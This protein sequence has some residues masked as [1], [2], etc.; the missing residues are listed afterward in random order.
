[1]A[2]N[3]ALVRYANPISDSS[4]WD[5]FRFRADDIVI[6]TPP[7]CGTTW[8]QMMCALLIFQ[9]PTFDRGLDRISPWLD[10]LTR[11]L[12]E[13]TADLDAQTHRRFVKTHTP[14]DGLPFDQRVTY[15]AVGR[16]PR[17]V[18][19]SWDHHVANSDID[20]FVA[21]RERATGTAGRAELAARFAPASDDVRDRFWD[22]IEK[23]DAPSLASTLHHV[24][25]FWPLRN[26]PNVVLMHYAELQ[27]DLEG[28]MRILAARLGIDV[29]EDLWPTVVQAA[30]FDAMRARAD[31]LAPDTTNRIW[32]DNHAFFHRGTSGQWHDFITDDRDRERYAR[33]VAELIPPDTSLWLHRGSIT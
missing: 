10:M 14:F 19:L 7:K 24:S 25:T 1:V 8:T 26:R 9:T 6:S 2:N 5:G 33:R 17:D 4:R 28:Q 11:P 13:V 15:I 21:A 31:E 3:R 29:A 18:A 20:A 27:A 16:D 30:S 22:W 12:D 32:H 23:P